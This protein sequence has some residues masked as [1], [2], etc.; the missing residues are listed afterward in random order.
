M[1]VAGCL[2]PAQGALCEKEQDRGY[3]A[4]QHLVAVFLKTKNSV[5]DFD[6]PE[7]FVAL[8][9]GWLRMNN[10]TAS[11]YCGILASFINMPSE[12]GRTFQPRKATH[13]KRETS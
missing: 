8:D 11:Y 9:S 10:T 3:G 5:P 12:N 13:S 7:Y 4:L 1:D 2:H 6:G